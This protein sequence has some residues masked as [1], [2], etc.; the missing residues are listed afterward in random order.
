MGKKDCRKAD[1]ADFKKFLHQLRK[2]RKVGDVTIRAYFAALSTFYDFLEFEDIIIKN[3]IIKFRRHYLSTLERG[4]RGQSNRQLIS[5]DQMRQLI[6]S[7]V[8]PRDK[9]I[10]TVLAKTGV[11]LS[12]LVAMDV[13]DINWAT[14]SIKLKPTG[15]RKKLIVFF[16]DECG[17]ILKRWISL[18]EKVAAPNEKALFVSYYGGRFGSREIQKNVTKYAAELGLHEYGSKDISK[19]FTPHCCRHWFT[20][21][22]RRSGM[23]REYVKELR[24]DVRDEPMDIYYHIDEEELREAY[25]A[26]IPQLGI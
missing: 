15:K 12:E 13:D 11:R 9:A 5:I 25:L 7:I 19:K 6:N 16:D 21:H 17:R 23:P 3:P 24:G 4:N 8:D 14:Q 2:E 18:R 22:L 26:H 10:V 1:T 20:T